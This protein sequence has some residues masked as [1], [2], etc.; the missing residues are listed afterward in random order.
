MQRR[1]DSPPITL[2]NVTRSG[3]TPSSPYQ[4]ERLTREPGHHF[5]ADEQGAVIC[6]Q[7]SQP[8]VEAW[9]RW[10]D[11][12][13]G[14]R[15]LGDH[16]R[17]LVTHLFEDLLGGGDVVVRK[18]NGVGRCAGRYSGVSG[19]PSV[20]TPEPAATRSESTCPW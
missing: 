18:H 8:R 19:N 12:H 5:V 10:H 14:C 13:V 11:S 20:A 17:D 2:P 7:L 1:G 9:Q 15:G 4:P 16:T 6:A 3:A